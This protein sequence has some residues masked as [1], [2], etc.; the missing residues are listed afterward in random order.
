MS[1]SEPDLVG[2]IRA[3][4]SGRE[5]EAIGYGRDVDDAIAIDAHGHVPV[6]RGGAFT[7]D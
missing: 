6:L 3:S 5:P 7:A 2:A 4:G 1:R